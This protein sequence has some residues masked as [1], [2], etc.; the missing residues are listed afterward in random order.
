MKLLQLNQLN[1]VAVENISASF[2]RLPHTNHKDG[3]Y[4]LRRYSVIEIRTTFWNAL[5]EAEITHLSHRDFVQSED[6]NK[7]QGG[8]VRSF[9]EIEE[10]VLQSD[11]LKE[12]CLTF[13]RANDLADGQ[14]I[15]VHQMRVSALAGEPFTHV[16]PEG[17]HQDG[18]D[19]I[20]V[21]GAGRHNIDG[22]D[23]MVLESEGAIQP[24]GKRRGH[25][26]FLIRQLKVGE[27]IIFADKELWHNAMPIR[28]N[29]AAPAY[30]D[31]LVLCANTK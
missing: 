5:E 6:L 16:A 10:E 20:A 21:I 11:A 22:G 29:T 31:W 4:R 8:E 12:A 18:F 13:K 28:R 19:H 9:E 1:R 24:D 30:G 3:E 17:V 26:P 14:E 2:G 27:M 15:E 7:H 25:R 23:L